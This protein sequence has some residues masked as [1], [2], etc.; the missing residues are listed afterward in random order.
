VDVVAVCTQHLATATE[1]ARHFGVPQAFDDVEAMLAG[2]D[3]DVVDVCVNVASHHRLVSLALSAEKHV[4]CEWPLGANVAETEALRDQA[5]AAGVKH[6]I[7]LQ[8]RA[9]PVYDYMRHLVADGY[10]GQVLSSAMNGSMS[11][12]PSPRSASL[13][14]IHAGHCMDTLFAVLGE[15]LDQGSSIV[16]TERLA[17]HLL[18]HGRLTGGSLVDVNVRHVP[19]FATGFTFEVNGTDGT[20]VASTDGANLPA[21]GIRSLGEQINQAALRGGRKG[22]QLTE[23]AVPL[24]HRWVPEEVPSGPPL[25]VAQT[26]RRFAESIRTDTRVEPDFEL[27]VRRH[28]LFD[29]IQ[30]NSERDATRPARSASRPQHTI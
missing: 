21:R 19:V 25:S 8:A 20:L 30:R 18:V 4:F 2:G 1:A 27:A 6:M 22:E 24:W 15:E 9:A 13:P 26:W 10:V 17:N 11:M 16:S 5:T 14:L 29:F 28:Q 3:V 12:D 7:G 23:M